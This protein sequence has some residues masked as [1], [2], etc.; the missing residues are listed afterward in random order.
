MTP[1]DHPLERLA[2]GGA[3]RLRARRVRRELDALSDRMRRDV[4]LPPRTP[5]PAALP[6]RY[7]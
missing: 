1:F 2:D 6:P 4:G 5:R 7:W 3:R